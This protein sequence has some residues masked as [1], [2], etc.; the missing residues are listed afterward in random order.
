MTLHGTCTDV[1]YPQFVSTVCTALP[2]SYPIL[3]DANGRGIIAAGR[4]YQ[5]QQLCEIDNAV[6]ERYT[7]FLYEC[8]TKN[9]VWSC[10]ACYVSS[11]M[12]ERQVRILSIIEHSAWQVLTSHLTVKA[13]SAKYVSQFL[14]YYSY[15]VRIA[16]SVYPQDGEWSRRDFRPSCVSKPKACA[17]RQYPIDRKLHELECKETWTSNSASIHRPTRMQHHF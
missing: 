1:R 6:H 2:L 5:L 9:I 15:V 14:F 3:N 7:M 17:W 10:C 8:A 12:Y 13:M 16:W 11:F 4:W